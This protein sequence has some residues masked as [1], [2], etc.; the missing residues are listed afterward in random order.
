MRHPTRFGLP[1]VPNAN[2]GTA[3][4]AYNKFLQTKLMDPKVDVEQGLRR[5]KAATLMILALPG[6]T[7]LYQ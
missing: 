4:A 7:Y 2:H 6:S 1:N 3:T 5:A